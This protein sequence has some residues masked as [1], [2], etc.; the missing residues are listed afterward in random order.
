[1][2]DE[3]DRLI[4]LVNDLLLLARADAGRNLESETVDIHAVIEETMRQAQQLD[5]EREL[6]TDINPGL[7]ILGD[8]DALKQ[9]MLILLDNAL[10][11]SEG[12]VD[13]HAQLQNKQVKIRVRDQGEGIPPKS[14]SIYSTVSTEGRTETPFPGLGWVCRSRSHW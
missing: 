1:M 14:W 6:A 9:V 10:K 12:K 2:V 13:I 3:S 11:H 8:R 7:S 4:C 5:L